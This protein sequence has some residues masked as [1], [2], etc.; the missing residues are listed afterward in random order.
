MKGIEEPIAIMLLMSIGLFTC[1]GV[2]F[3]VANMLASPINAKE[4]SPKEMNRFEIVKLEFMNCV[5]VNGSYNKIIF[6]NPT[7][8]TITLKNLTASLRNENYTKIGNVSFY[9]NAEP[10][11]TVLGHTNIPLSQGQQYRVTF[12]E[13]GLPDVVIICY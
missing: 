5:K 13:I 9:E 4:F 6:Y 1:V 7:Y 11:G 2:W 8:K 3:F 12:E 10:Y